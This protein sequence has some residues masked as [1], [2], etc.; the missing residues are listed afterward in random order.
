MQESGQ[1]EGK[2]GRWELSDAQWQL[3]EPV[4]R[5][6]RRSHGRGRSW[7]DIRRVLNGI[8][9]V[10]GTGAQWRELQQVSAVPDLPPLLPA[11]GAR[12]QTGAHHG[13]RSGR[14]LRHRDDR[15]PSRR[16][17]GIH[18]GGSPVAALPQALASGT[19]LCLAAPFSPLGY[20]LGV[21]RRELF[22][23]GAPRLHTNLA[24]AIMSRPT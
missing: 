20:R 12:G 15:T 24:Q 21:S 1:K 14:A 3:I 13:P 7:Q 9:W 16:A 10:L 4:L 22:R 17:P 19:T 8:L 2:R 5:P 23:H 11:V 18:T 6:Q